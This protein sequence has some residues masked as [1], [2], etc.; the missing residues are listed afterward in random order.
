MTTTSGA[1]RP[2]GRAPRA[3]IPPAWLPRMIVGAAAMSL[4]IVGVLWLHGGGVANTTGGGAPA[5]T[6]IGRLAGLAAADLLMIQVLLMARIPWIEREFGQDSLA[7][8][9]RYV[10]FTSFDLMVLHIVLVAIGYA[11]TDRHGILYESWYLTTTYPAMLLAVA[12]FAALVLVVVTS[13]R[14][15]RRKLRYE[16][17]HLLH[18][19]AYVG[20]GL[21][22]PHELWTGADFI[23]TPIARLYWWTAYI[24]AAASILIFRIGTPVWRSVRHDL[25]VAAVVP[26]A[27]GVHSIYLRGRDLHRLSVQAGHFFNWRFLNGSGWMRAHPFSLSAAPRPDLLRITV[28]DLGDGT[29]SLAGSLRAGTRVLIEGPYGRLTGAVRR[30]HRITFM[31]CGIGITPLRALLET[32]YYRPGEAVLIYRAGNAEEFTFAAEIERLAR[33]RGVSVVYLPGPRGAGNTWIPS[34]YGNPETLLR[35]TVPGIADSDVYICG[36]EPWMDAVR[37]SLDRLAVPPEH[38]HLERFAW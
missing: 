11:G 7:R 1:R 20:V 34:G 12:G 21:S 26:E 8:W 30:H 17:W 35:S 4:V 29:G 23:L 38:V 27:D 10:G 24:L 18:L 32:E 22:L 36:P 28:K 6:S 31:A 16:S 25:R 37:E 14:A 5:V 33:N 13:V 15:A 2:V 19:Y 3:G 9:H